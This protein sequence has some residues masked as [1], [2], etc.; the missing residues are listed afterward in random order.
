MINSQVDLYKTRVSLGL[1]FTTYTF[2]E[3]HDIPHQVEI[4]RSSKSL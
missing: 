1:V 2:L 4:E 3:N